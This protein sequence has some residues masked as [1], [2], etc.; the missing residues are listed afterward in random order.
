MKTFSQYITE[1]GV[2]PFKIAGKPAW[3]ESL[4]TMLFDLPRAGLKDIKIPLSPAIMRRIWPKPI[5]TTVFHLTD[6]D[7]LGK[8]KKMQGGKR[9]V[10]AFFNIDDIIIQSGIKSEGGYIAEM[11]ADVLVASQD[12]ISSQPDKTGRRWITVSSLMNK[13]TDPDPG[14]GG[15]AKLKGMEKDIKALLTEI[16]KKNSEGVKFSGTTS[17][18]ATMWSGLGKSTGG[19][20]KSLIIKDY[21]D[22]MEK[23]MKKHSKVLGS[24]LTDY[25]KK[26]VQEPDPDSGDRPMWDE[27]VVNNFKIE[28][29]HVVTGDDPEDWDETDFG[30]PIKVWNDRHDA[31]DYIIR[32]VQKIKL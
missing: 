15:G 26:R 29:V 3:T 6:Y 25:T 30:L 13:P 24:L 10:S 28:K 5:R 18:I 2:S 32:T 4:S 8:L 16:V 19:K 12:D 14:L 22:G 21:I 20:E 11:D 9:S 17:E 1:L 7:G 31:A 23:I 27:L